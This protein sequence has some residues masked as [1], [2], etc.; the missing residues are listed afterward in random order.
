MYAC[1]LIFQLVGALLLLL[2]GINGSREKV[3]ANC[4]SGSNN[5]ERDENGICTIPATKLQKSASVIYLNNIAF[6]DLVI[7]Y[8]IATFSPMSSSESW[9][10]ALTVLGGTTILLSLQFFASFVLSKWKY[11]HDLA[12]PYEQ[13]EKYDVDTPMTMAEIDELCK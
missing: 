5:A 1:M 4:F 13:L 9:I 6:G 8:G 12:I 7:G 3:I 10:T 2:N 11:P